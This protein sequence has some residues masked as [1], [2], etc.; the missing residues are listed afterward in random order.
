MNNPLDTSTTSTIEHEEMKNGNDLRIFRTKKK[1]S[2]PD[3]VMKIFNF[4]GKRYSINYLYDIERGKRALTND[5]K[6]YLKK[7]KNWE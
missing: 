6:E 3:F 2:M 1:K 4:T 5:V 7:V